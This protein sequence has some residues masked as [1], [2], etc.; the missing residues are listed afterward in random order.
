MGPTEN[1]RRQH[2]EARELIKH[3]QD[4]SFAVDDH[5][6]EL[7]A[8]LAKLRGALKVHLAMEDK[9]LYPSLLAHQDPNIA[10]LARRFSEEMTGLAGTFLDFTKG[11]AERGAME[12]APEKFRSELKAVARMLTLR[13]DR[14]DRELYP[15]LEAGEQILARAGAPQAAAGAR[16]RV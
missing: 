6:D 13:M 10:T 2:I 3:I 14:E 16:P 5:A 7:R 11:W 1:F 9:S 15:L 12:K 4:L 8:M